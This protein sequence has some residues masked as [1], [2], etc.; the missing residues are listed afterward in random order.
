M[1]AGALTVVAVLS[2]G[3][4]AISFGSIFVRLA[5]QSAGESGLG[6]SLVMSALRM[7]IASLL[8]LPAWWGL[9]TL[10][11]HRNPW[12]HA[13]GAGLF[14]AL[15]FATWITS[16]GL[17]SIAASTVLVTST[18]V[19]MALFSWWWLG[20]PPS[21]LTLLAIG[22]ALGGAAVVGLADAGNSPAKDPLLGNL[23]ALCGAL[24]AAVYL[25]LGREAQ[26][27]GMGIG[28]Y[29]AVAYTTAALLLLP[30][31]PLLGA[32]YLG[33]PPLTYLWIA[34]MAL[35]P[36]LLGHTS[37]NWAM[38]RIHPVLVSLVTLLEPV[39]ASLLALL[40]FAEV[41]SVQVVWGGVL[42]LVGVGLAVWGNRG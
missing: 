17:T 14:L 13:L 25:I 22:I 28:V 34:L 7:G 12:P 16:L 30:L 20:L 29:I 39:G 40:I 41:P 2:V 11:A 8:L 35:F 42:L 4:A 3:I 23:L 31:P 21:R 18:P 1:R 5:S 26:R 27:R 19:W 38:R 6:F 10:K 9:R 32:G 33:Y 15:H 37:L 36:Q 24:A